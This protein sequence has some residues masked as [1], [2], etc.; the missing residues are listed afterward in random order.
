MFQ[1]RIAR[2]LSA[3]LGLMA[4]SVAAYLVNADAAEV[5]SSLT[6][7]TEIEAFLSSDAF[8]RGVSVLE[9]TQ[10]Q[11]IYAERNFQPIWSGSAE[12]RGRARGARGVLARA[13][14]H[15]L[16]PDHYSRSVNSTPENANGER[17]AQIDIEVTQDVLRYARD[18]RTGRLA[19]SAVYRDTDLPQ[20]VFDS[21]AALASAVRQGEIVQFFSE[22]PPPQPEYRRLV[23]TLEKYRGI[24]THGGW[25]SIPGNREIKTDGSDP[26]LVVLMRRLQVEDPQAA[27]PGADPVAALKRYQARNGLTADGRAGALTLEMLNVSAAERVAQI[28]ANLERWRWLPRTFENRYIAVN[29]PD[30]SLSFIESGKILLNSR[31]IIGQAR[32]PTPIF[33]AT[34]LA[35][36][37]NPPWNVPH[38]I[39][40]NEILPR[41]KRDSNY[42]ATQNMVLL[43][44]TADDPTGVDVNWR[45][46]SADRFAYRI[47]QLPGDRNAL[48]KLKFELP[49]RFSVYLHDTPGKAAFDRDQRA[50]SH[51]CIRV[52]EIL[53]LAVLAMGGDAEAV[54]GSLNAS[55]A[56]GATV[57]IPLPEPLPV[58]VLYWTVIAAEDGS[59]GF[60]RDLYGRDRRLNAA[61]RE[62]F[63]AVMP[64]AELAGC[65]Y[66]G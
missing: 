4:F 24:E 45:G 51:G 26:R 15:G 60:R 46:V 6:P 62:R 61:L 5:P 29:V 64:T 22:L 19:P 65:P 44:G 43:N 2:Y 47:Q 56:A 21:A 59:V 20:D 42:L 28:A 27:M 38:S 7:T 30:Q 50:L 8:E 3:S 58:Y 37:V 13:A 57:Q 40:I 34:A 25:P 48:G 35:I 32:T 14:E 63:A 54:E 33:R 41:L 9:R 36:T 17:L 52:Q 1:Q 66:A 49:N 31:V 23:A 11:R 39:A 10:L 16:D 55:I 53:P 18:V 12:G